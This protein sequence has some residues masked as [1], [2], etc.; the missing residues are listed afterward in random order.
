[1]YLLTSYDSYYQRLLNFEHKKYTR[2]SGNNKKSTV[3][4]IVQVSFM[5]SIQKTAP[6]INKIYFST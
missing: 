2:D 5:K 1:M 4:M 6:R 3:Y